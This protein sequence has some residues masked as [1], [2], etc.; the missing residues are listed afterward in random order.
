MLNIWQVYFNDIGKKNCYPEFNHYDNSK[1][2]TEHF[3]NSVIVDLIDKEEHKKT[4][5][6]GVF[7]H[8][9]RKDMPF[10]ENG[11]PFSPE[12]LET[13]IQ[14]NQD[15]DVFAF[16]K[17]RKQKNIVLQAENYHKGFVEIVKKILRE[18][19]F[20]DDWPGRGKWKDSKDLPPTLD[21]I[22][23]FNYFIARG[24]VYERYVNELLRPAMK[25]LEGIPEAYNNATYKKL[26]TQEIGRFTQAFGKPYYPFHPFVLERLPSI[27]MQKYKYNFK[28]VF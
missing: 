15:I 23:L 20:L 5:Y 25:I 6:F 24:A 4:E 22:I 14:Q 27:F 16:Q 10:K 21:Y 12:N 28:H 11:L 7:S 3:E 9:I 18:T 1:K 8:D 2:L 19:G 26:N 13:V 17:R